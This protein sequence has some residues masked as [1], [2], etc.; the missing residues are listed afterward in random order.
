MLITL[1]GQPASLSLEWQKNLYIQSTLI[2][3]SKIVKNEGCRLHTTAPGS[4]V[5]RGFKHLKCLWEAASSIQQGRSGHPSVSPVGAQM[6]LAPKL[7]LL[8]TLLA[9]WTLAGCLLSGVCHT[10]SLCWTSEKMHLKLGRS[11]YSGQA[12]LPSCPARQ[13]QQVLTEHCTT[14]HWLQPKRQT[15]VPNV[16]LQIYFQMHENIRE[17]MF[18]DQPSKRRKLSEK[19]AGK[20]AGMFTNSHWK[21]FGYC[22]KQ[23]ALNFI[24]VKELS[25][26]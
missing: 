12:A 10:T 2:K 4:D 18:V 22:C 7:P 13:E 6:L 3:Y 26:P 1:S 8:C 14:G 16:F 11:M 25:L 9:A 5:Q 21:M 20:A 23:P 17:V 24:N 15:L 19:G